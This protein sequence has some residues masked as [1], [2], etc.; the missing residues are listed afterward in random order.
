MEIGLKS[1][2][3]PK[4]ILFCCDHNA[5]RSPMAEGMIKKFYGKA[6]YAQSAGV[7]ND[8][9]IDGYSISVCEEI[10]VELSR[11]KTRSFDVM[12]KLGDDISSFDLIVALSPASQHRALELTAIYDLKI[13]YWPIMD[14]TGLGDRREEKLIAYSLARDQIRN[15][16]LKRFGNQI[17]EY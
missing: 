10:S 14:P 12:S 15:Q 5:V 2:N 6:I 3:L 16:I 9:E 4:S 1:K 13:E 7:K 11:H 8:L 17:P